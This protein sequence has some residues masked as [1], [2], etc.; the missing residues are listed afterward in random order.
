MAAPTIPVSDD[1][2]Q[3]SFG[4]TIDIDVDVI[5]LEELTNLRFRVDIA[6]AENASLHATI[7]TMKVIE[8][9]TRNHKRLARIEIKR[10]LA[11]VQQSH[12]QDLEDFRKLKDFMT[13]QY[14]YHS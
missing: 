4:D 13:S 9:V 10:H 11:S 7:K 5:H 6:E 2:T 12:R 14:G 8:K 1:S 3:G